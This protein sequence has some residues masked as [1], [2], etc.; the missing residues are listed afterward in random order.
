MGT[1][2]WSSSRH[3]VS[4]TSIPP[5]PTSTSDPLPPQIRVSSGTS[6]APSA[7]ATSS[8]KLGTNGS[9]MQ[10]TCLAS[11]P[12]GQPAINVTASAARLFTI[13]A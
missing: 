11:A 13:L 6:V 10:R 1:P 5:S 9:S 4:G 2:T 7:G 8:T 3:A 12:R